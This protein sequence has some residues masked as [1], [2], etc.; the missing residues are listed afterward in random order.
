MYGHS[1]NFEKLQKQV[2]HLKKRKLINSVDTGE[3]VH[4]IFSQKPKFS[5]NITSTTYED[6]H[7]LYNVLLL[8]KYQNINID[9]LRK[10]K[11]RKEIKNE[12][13]TLFEE[14]NATSNFSTN[15]IIDNQQDIETLAI[16][17]NNNI[18]KGDIQIMV[19]NLLKISKMQYNDEIKLNY[20]QLK[21]YDLL[22][23]F[24]NIFIEASN[25]P[26]NTG[27]NIINYTIYSKLKELIDFPSIQLIS[28]CNIIGKY[29]KKLLINGILSPL[30]AEEN[31]EKF[32][33]HLITK[34][35][36]E[37]KFTVEEFIIL[38]K[39]FSTVKYRNAAYKNVGLN[40]HHLTILQDI[41]KQKISLNNDILKEI[42]SV[43]NL[44]SISD[45]K[46][47]KSHGMFLFL[48]CKDL[49]KVKISNEIYQELLRLSELNETFLKKKIK[50]TLKKFHI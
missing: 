36:K 26:Y 35:F 14:N 31:F 41:I 37:I 32:Q 40:E 5:K 23:I 45:I 42:I 1:N 38:L 29:N 46:T 43:Y 16:E 17:C 12:S 6:V 30:L 50:D 13:E 15:N 11:K 20:D 33:A 19:K 9:L 3:T 22:Q 39:N 48:L 8:S 24:Q 18:K 21:D 4:T 47:S 34:I 28:I 10:V 49:T 25:V 44:F 7:S 27:L 2:T